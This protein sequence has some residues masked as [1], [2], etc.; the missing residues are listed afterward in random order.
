MNERT[1]PA[2]RRLHVHAEC[3]GDLAPETSHMEKEKVEVKIQEDEVE[4]GRT[5]E[6]CE[7]RVEERSNTQA[8]DTQMR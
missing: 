4:G 7:A 1:T 2:H 5:N 6:E 8:H 3:T